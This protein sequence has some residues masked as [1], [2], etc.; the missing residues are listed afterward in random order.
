MPTLTVEENVA[1]PLLLDGCGRRAV[2]PRVQGALAAVALESR[3]VHFP[4]QLSGGE[5]QRAA[6]AR[7]LV[8]APPIVLAD[9]PSGNLDR[10]A[11]ESLQDLIFSLARNEGETF[12]IVTHDEKL[13]GRADLVLL[14]DDGHLEPL[15]DRPFPAGEGKVESMS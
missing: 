11:S 10:I 8:V 5:Q 7:A 13:A 1:L 2:R 4:D 3:A 12:V 15:K 14:L 9:E 6:I